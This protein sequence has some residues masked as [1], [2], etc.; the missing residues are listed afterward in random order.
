V[1]KRQP[2]VIVG[3]GEFAQIACEYFTCDSPYEVVGFAVE[4]AFQDRDEYCD[5]PVVALEEAAARFDPARHA[6]YVAVTYTQLNRVRTRLLAQTRGLGFTPAS[7]VSSH[8]FV[9]RNVTIGEHCFVFEHNVLQHFARIG[10]N[11]VLWSGNHIGHRSVVGDNCFISSHV[12]LSG[13]AEI[14]RNGFVG[15]NSSIHDRV[16]IGDDVAIGA[17]S[18]VVDDIGEGRVLRGNPAIA[19]KAGSLRLFRVGRA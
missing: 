12:V 1:I 5:R 10:D 8:A 11:V 16:R 2:L 3:A 6:A 14:G 15:V 7:Y 4:R 17:G 18:V 19:A 13:Y 9:W